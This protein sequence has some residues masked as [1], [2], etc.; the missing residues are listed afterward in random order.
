MVFSAI[1]HV[2]EL[3]LL[4]AELEAHRDDILVLTCDLWVSLYL[5]VSGY[6]RL[7]RLI[8]TPLRAFLS[9]LKAFSS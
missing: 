6:S 4:P 3:I 5:D 7:E 1:F 8:T 9:A 2:S